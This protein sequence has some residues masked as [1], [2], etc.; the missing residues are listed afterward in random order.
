MI[1]P[2][3]MQYQLPLTTADA[4]FGLL[5]IFGDRDLLTAAAAPGQVW[6]AVPQEL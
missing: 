2:S 5:G 1:Y 3:I 6:S 4:R